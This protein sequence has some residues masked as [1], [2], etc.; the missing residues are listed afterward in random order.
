VRELENVIRRAIVLRDFDFVFKELKLEQKDAQTDHPAIPEKD[1][2]QRQWND[3]KV[4]RFFRKS[5]FS[6][7]R[8]SKVYVS[9][10]EREAILKALRETQWNRKQAAKLLKVSYKTLRNRIREFDISP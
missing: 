8:I 7:K 4:K 3:E 2:P 5:D 9:E 10:I 6:L 1:S